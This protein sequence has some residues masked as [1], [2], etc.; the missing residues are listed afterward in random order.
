MVIEN[1]SFPSM[2]ATIPTIMDGGNH[3]H[4]SLIIKYT[5]Y[6]T[7]ETGTSWEYPYKPG[8]IPTINTNTTVAHHK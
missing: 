8:S 2:A 3:G 7:L 1:R 5:L 6:A 4:V